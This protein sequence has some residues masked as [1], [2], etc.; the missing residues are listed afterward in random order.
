MVFRQA[1]LKVK[2]ED[3][4]CFDSQYSAISVLRLLLLLEKEK[5]AEETESNVE[6]DYL[7]GLSGSLMDHNEERREEQPGIW[8]FEEEC[9]VDFIHQVQTSTC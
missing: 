6:D 7:L 4:E 9:M 1:G 2:V 3:I 8:E 5:L